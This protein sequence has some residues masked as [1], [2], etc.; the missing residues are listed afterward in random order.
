MFFTHLIKISYFNSFSY[1]QV[2][3]EGENFTVETEVARM[4]ELVR[5]MLDGEMK[6]VATS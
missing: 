2:S 6:M 3:K 1:E 4:S 5:A